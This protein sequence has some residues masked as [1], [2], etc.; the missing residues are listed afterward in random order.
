MTTADR[1]ST[2]PVAI[3]TGA[4]APYTHV[5]YEALA[6]RLARPLT[7]LTCTQ[8]ETARQWVIGRPQH[9]RHEVLPGLR[10]HRDTVRNLYVNP[11]VAGRRRPRAPPAGRRNEF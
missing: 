2:A 11:S 9:Y 8:R 7:V 5:L 10:W 1:S 3:V 6:Q 4:L